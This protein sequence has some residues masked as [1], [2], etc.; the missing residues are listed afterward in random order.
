MDTT[1]LTLFGRARYK[2]LASLWGMPDADAVHLRELA[3][4]I[5][6]SPT[7]TQYELR[8]LVATGLVL[9]DD[10]SGRT[11]YRANR[12]HL[13]APELEAMIRKMD[14]NREVATIADDAFWARKR[15]TQ[16]AD[17]ASKDPG[18]KSTFLSNRKLASALSAD[19]HKDVSYDYQA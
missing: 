6:L 13:I 3:R 10:A 12:K 11:L 14:A 1:A 19:L 4:R 9:M 15:S 8:L 16:K 2:V 18:R 5:G 17:Y 7:A